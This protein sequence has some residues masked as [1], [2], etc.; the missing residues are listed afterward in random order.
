MVFGLLKQ[1]LQKF[2]LIDAAISFA[3]LEAWLTCYLSYC[4]AVCVVFVITRWSMRLSLLPILRDSQVVV[5]WHE[6]L[7]FHLL[8]KVRSFFFMQ[9][10][11]LSLGFVE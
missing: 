7:G 1:R 5:R 9:E 8:C 6:Y 2:S 4:D 11:E 3:N 10:E